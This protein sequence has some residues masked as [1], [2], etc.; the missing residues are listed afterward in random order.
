MDSFFGTVAL[1]L[2]LH[3]SRNSYLSEHPQGS[4]GVV[5]VKGIKQLL[6]EFVLLIQAGNIFSVE[7]RAH[8]CTHMYVFIYTYVC[9]YI[10]LHT[11]S[12]CH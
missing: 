1:F 11:V 5:P 3:A 6:P 12:M 10:Y 9:V 2:Q 4:S 8:I 7:I